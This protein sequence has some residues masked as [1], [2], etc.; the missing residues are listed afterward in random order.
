MLERYNDPTGGPPGAI[1]QANLGLTLSDLNLRMNDALN[2]VIAKAPVHKGR[3]TNNCMGEEANNAGL[4]V[5][6]IFILTFSLFLLSFCL[7]FIVCC[8]FNIVIANRLPVRHLKMA[9][10]VNSPSTRRPDCGIG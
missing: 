6:F 9:P 3:G 7:F 8:C 2:A 10:Y 5:L 1:S 4:S